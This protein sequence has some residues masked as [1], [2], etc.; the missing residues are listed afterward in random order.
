M[1]YTTI[2]VDTPRIH[3]RRITLNRPEALNGYTPTMCHELIDAI[4]AYGADD[5]ARCLI[6]T[7]AG[8]G[9]CSGG[10]IKK[11]EGY[12]MAKHRRLGHGVVMREGNHRLGLALHRLDKPTIAAINGP[13]VAGGLA[14]A[15]FCDLRIAAD[16]AKLGDTSG[17]FALLP[18]EGG[19]WLLPRII[20]LDRALRMIWLSEVVDARTALELGL[21]S[22]VVPAESLMDAALEL[23]GRIAGRSP[24]AVR[25]AKRL[26]ARGLEQ[27]LDQA[28]GET[29]LSVLAVNGSA[30]AHEGIAAFAEKRPPV[31]EGR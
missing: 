1:S 4:A 16:T 13:A 26:A 23:A 17:N 5:D 22:D 8:R 24:V 11:L 21:V 3:V 14:L 10:D 9:F 2:L 19:A 6:L 25:L 12:E 20:G 29:E 27:N 31:F 15:L 30:D 7:G 28:L 18:D